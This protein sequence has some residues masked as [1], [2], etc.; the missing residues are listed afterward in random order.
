MPPTG[1]YLSV[2]LSRSA[3]HAAP[4]PAPAEPDGGRYP[5]P[6][7]MEPGLSSPGARQPGGWWSPQRPLSPL[8]SSF[9]LMRSG[10]SRAIEADRIPLEGYQLP[11]TR[12]PPMEFPRIG[13]IFVYESHSTV[14]L[15]RNRFSELTGLVTVDTLKQD[16]LRRAFAGFR[17]PASSKNGSFP[18]QKPEN[19]LKVSHVR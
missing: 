11:W 4:L 6:C 5:P 10:G 7:P 13:P 8:R 12:A 9:I 16:L 19:A 17:L 15:T 3:F 1:R 2:A 14:V 18:G